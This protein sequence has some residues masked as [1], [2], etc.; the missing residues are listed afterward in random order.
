MI[1]WF[2]QLFGWFAQLFGWFAQLFGWLARLLVTYHVA[3]IIV[4][5]N[6]TF[7]EGSFK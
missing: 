3:A 5:G 4:D 7:L 2:A 1:G 6:I